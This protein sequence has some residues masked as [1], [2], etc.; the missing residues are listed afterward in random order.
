LPFEDVFPFP[1]DFEAVFF[2]ESVL[3]VSFLVATCPEAL[4][5]GAFDCW[6]PSTGAA[7]AIDAR[8][9]I[10]LRVIVNSFDRLVVLIPSSRTGT[11]RLP[12][13]IGAARATMFSQHVTGNHLN[14]G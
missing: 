14:G 6:A 10:S 13:G 12:D 5:A 9:A 1:L 2:V 3:V 11:G 7:N 4:G 8:K